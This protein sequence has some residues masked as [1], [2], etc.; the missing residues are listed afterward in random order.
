MGT[1]EVIMSAI[2]EQ[3]KNAGEPTWHEV[4][5]ERKKREFEQR[6]QG[7][8]IKEGIGILKCQLC[9]AVVP[10]TEG[11]LF[12]PTLSDVP[13]ELRQTV[14]SHGFELPYQ[15]CSDCVTKAQTT[16]PRSHFDRELNL[17]PLELWRRRH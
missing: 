9:G 3:R 17:T 14:L 6:K 5:S 4:N 2:D 8:N 11:V 1:F 13:P 7:P 10:Y 12:A 15:L 16:S